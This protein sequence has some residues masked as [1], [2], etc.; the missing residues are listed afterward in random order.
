M[1]RKTGV[2]GATSYRY[3]VYE[4]RAQRRC[5]A[6][7]STGP[8][9]KTDQDG[10]RRRITELQAVDLAASDSLCGVTRVSHFDD[11]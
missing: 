4:E 6:R 8:S 2:A 1:I 3:A 7:C 11:P 5:G 10:P 9:W